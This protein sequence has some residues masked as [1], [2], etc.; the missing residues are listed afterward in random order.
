MLQRMSLKEYVAFMREKNIFSPHAPF[1]EHCPDIVVD[2][3]GRMA[4]YGYDGMAAAVTVALEKYAVAL[5]PLDTQRGGKN[6]AMA[7]SM[8]DFTLPVPRAAFMAD[9]P[10]L[11]AAYGDIAVMTDTFAFTDGYLAA[12][13]NP[14]LPCLYSPVAV[15]G[16]NYDT[17][18]EELSQERR[19]KYRRFVR[20]FDENG[21]TFSLSDTPLSEGEIKFALDNLSRKWGPDGALFAFSQTLWAHCVAAHRPDHALFM[22]VMDKDR[23]V[24]VQTVLR[25]HGGYYAQSIFKDEDS[26]YDGIAPYTDFMTIKALCARGPSFFDPSCRTGFEDPES[27]G[28]AK[29]ATVNTNIIKPVFM[30]GAGLAEQWADYITHPALHGKAA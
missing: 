15:F 9:Y 14:A 7:T 25:R 16:D 4:S 11:A 6:W 18:V 29:R 30:A 10:A 1:A 2:F 23:L 8:V 28:I 5:D 27:I 21:L 20:D 19:K 24:F 13:E 12:D 3:Y 26:F 22:R 17:Y